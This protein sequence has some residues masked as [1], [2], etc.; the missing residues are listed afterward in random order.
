MVQQPRCSDPPRKE[1][2]IGRNA[3]ENTVVMHQ[4]VPLSCRIQTNDALVSVPV[5]TVV[6]DLPS[7]LA[8]RQVPV[9]IGAQ[10]GKEET[11]AVYSPHV[12]RDCPTS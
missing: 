5:M 6:A 9:P 12:E 1:S 3:F 8:H 2:A 10:V 11:V 7:R 4:F